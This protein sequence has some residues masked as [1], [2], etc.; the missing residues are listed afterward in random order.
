MRHPRL[1]ATGLMLSCIIVA[2]CRKQPLPQSQAST[3]ELQLHPEQ[4]LVFDLGL[5][6][7]GG[8]PRGSSSYLAVYHLAADVGAD[9]HTYKILVERKPEF[10]NIA[11]RVLDDRKSLEGPTGHQ[12]AFN[13]M[14]DGFNKALGA[15]NAVRSVYAYEF[16]TITNP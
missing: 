5:V 8:R 10:L 14:R 2:G 11:E 15:S 3:T 6:T 16:R 13:R 1:F 7:S 9:T 4:R 12:A